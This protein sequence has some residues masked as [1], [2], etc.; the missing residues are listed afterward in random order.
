MLLGCN[1][2]QQLSSIDLPRL[3]C[4]VPSHTSESCVD[5]AQPESKKQ[6][7]LYESTDLNTDH[8]TFR[9]NILS[10]LINPQSSSGL[11]SLKHG[12][13]QTLLESFLPNVLEELEQ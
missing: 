7:S 5:H 4:C 10:D 9:P 6:F 1:D 13:R 8:S 11:F 2:R 12:R 3:T